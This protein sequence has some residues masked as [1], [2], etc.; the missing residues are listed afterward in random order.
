MLVQPKLK[1]LPSNQLFF[2]KI[3]DMS[4]IGKFESIWRTLQYG[5]KVEDQFKDGTLLKAVEKGLAVYDKV[6]GSLILET[7][8]PFI[9]YSD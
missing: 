3:L 6:R 5:A 8:F 9:L 7:V 1:T 2:R 4:N